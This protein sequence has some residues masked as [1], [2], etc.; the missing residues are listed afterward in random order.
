[1]TQSDINDSDSITFA[2]E[3]GCGKIY[4]RIWEPEGVFDRVFIQGSISKTQDCGYSWMESMAGVITFALRK[5]IQEALIGEEI[6]SEPIE[7]G[8]I[9]RLKHQGCNKK[10]SCV[11]GIAVA[12]EKYLTMRGW[13]EEKSTP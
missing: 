10:P 6:D 9:K 8:I 7:K 12:L 11:H 13:I 3:C 2:E 4:I 1:M 5:A